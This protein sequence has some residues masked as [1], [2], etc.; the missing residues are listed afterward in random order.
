MESG[1]ESEM[2]SYFPGWELLYKVST[3]G[4]VIRC[5]RVVHVKRWG[6]REFRAEYPEREVGTHAN[7]RGV[8][9]LK[10]TRQGYTLTLNVAQAVMQTFVG[11]CPEGQEVCHED[12]NPLNNC[13]RNLRYDTHR[14]NMKDQI[15]HGTRP[16]KLTE[17]QIKE[18]RHRA[19]INR[20]S[21]RSIA[22]E[23]G[24][25][26]ATVLDIIHK[27]IWAHV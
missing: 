7:K 16:T 13:L 2:W 23:Y 11:P 17:I 5:A 4:R 25:N 15:K 26:H 24:L 8:K 22:K 27:R 14:N 20:H 12:G 3:R 6:Q 1:I 19:F 21:A 9:S 10:F 18:I